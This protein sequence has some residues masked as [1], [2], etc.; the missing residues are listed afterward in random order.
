MGQIELLQLPQKVQALLG[1]FNEVVDRQLPF[2]VLSNDRVQE[3][4]DSTMAAAESCS[5]L[6]VLRDGLLLESNAS[7]SGH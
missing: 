2:K 5:V 4:Y 6:W 3:C 7:S 1:R